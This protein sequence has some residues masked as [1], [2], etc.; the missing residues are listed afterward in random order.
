MKFGS[1]HINNWGCHS[2]KMR[3]SIMCTVTTPRQTIHLWPEWVYIN[4]FTLILKKM[5]HFSAFLNHGSL[6]T[7]VINWYTT[8]L[9]FELTTVWIRSNDSWVLSDWVWLI[10]APP[11]I[12]SLLK[13]YLCTL[14]LYK[15]WDPW[16]LCDCLFKF[17][18][19]C[20]NTCCDISVWK[21]VVD[22]PAD[23]FCHP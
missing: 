7:N 20:I 16:T 15:I 18:W 23:W 1:G 14:G 17:S 12:G 8:V 4:E 22:Q 11:W 9:L 19:Q 6:L 5:L 21:K 3:G 13:M 10:S 2:W